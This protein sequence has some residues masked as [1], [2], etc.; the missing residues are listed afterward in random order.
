MDVLIWTSLRTLLQGR[1]MLQ[2]PLLSFEQS[3]GEVLQ[4]SGMLLFVNRPERFIVLRSE[5][6]SERVEYSLPHELC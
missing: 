1:D 3:V 4:L 2:P 6:C 5:I